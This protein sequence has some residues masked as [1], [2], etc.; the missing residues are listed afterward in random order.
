MTPRS[1]LFATVALCLF[2][3]GRAQDAQFTQ[4]YAA[5][6]YLSPAF[7]GTS[8]QSRFS[9]MYRD[10]WPSIPGAFVTYAAAFDH[11]A[12]NVNSGFG[13]QLFHDRSGSGA[14]RYTSITGQYAYE[15]QLKRKVFLRPAL[16]FAFVNHAVDYSRL[17]F[18]DQLARGGTVATYEN[19]D[20]RSINYSDAGFGLLYFTP[21]TWLGLSF[22]H[23]NQ[24]NQ[25]LLMNES[26]VPR[27]F[28]VHGGRRFAMRSA[29]IKQHK[30]SVVVAFNYRSQEKYD[31]LDLG[32]YYE[33]HPFYAGLWYRGLPV[34]KAY[35][36][37]Y[38]NSD[39]VA[40]I[41]GV[42]VGDWRFGYGYDLTISKLA[43]YT[44]GS[45]EI[46]T[47]V[48]FADRRTRRAKYKKRSIPC[49]K[50]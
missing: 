10:Q 25:S 21:R 38:G 48:E 32:F 17:T 3:V 13:V 29:V 31:Q 28:S 35:A 40:A 22:H 20:G 16:E 30:Q 2:S 27:K 36:A 49:A 1:A 43:G 34:F 41:V 14:L 9:M 8:L 6:T 26:R 42:M 4:F 33:Q 45:H 15:I 47:A 24:P 7:A 12:S 37:G 11:Y 46:S 39:A 50:F 23:L 5:P 44:A 19:M 18:G